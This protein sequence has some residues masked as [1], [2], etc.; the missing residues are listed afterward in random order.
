MK[1]F[2]ILAAAFAVGSLTFV[3]CSTTGSPTLPDV[4]TAAS[5]LTNFLS[6]AQQGLAIASNAYAQYQQTQQAF[7]SLQGGATQADPA[8]SDGACEVKAKAAPFF[9]GRQAQRTAA[10]I[11]GLTKVDP[12]KYGGWN[13][14]CPGCD[15]D[16]QAF[17]IACRSEGV[18][19]E[20]L[21]NAQA[22][23]IGIV[24]S[25]KRAVA[26]LGDGDLLILYI[27][28]H[29]GQQ[30]DTSGDEKDNLDETLCLWDGQLSDDAVWQ[31]LAQ[32]PK[33]V[34]IWMVTDTCNSGTNYRAPHSYRARLADGPMLLHWGGC[35]DGKSSF[36]SAQGGTFTTALVDSYK[37]GQSYAAWFASAKR[38]MPFTQRPTCET[39]AVDFTALPAFR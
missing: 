23:Y 28:G 39:V 25:A 3:G 21:L 14:D 27:S 1:R 32:V 5:T 11:C 20:L 12:K 29:G 34:R 4:Q 15:V 33:G 9:A 24:A 38:R 8:C 22:S 18:P 31:L 19:Y 36:G 7:A 16:A 13:G 37:T 17:A 6:Q 35:A 10:V 2:M 30:A 26:T